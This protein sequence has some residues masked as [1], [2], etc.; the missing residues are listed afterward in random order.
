[1]RSCKNGPRAVETDIDRQLRLFLV[2]ADSCSVNT[3]D[4]ADILADWQ[5]FEFLGKKDD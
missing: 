2:L 4:F 3:N 5:I 1:L